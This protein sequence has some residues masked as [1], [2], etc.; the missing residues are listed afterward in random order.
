MAS[1]QIA[2][3]NMALTHLGQRTITS[4]DEASEPARKMKLIWES[5]RDEVLADAE[6]TFATK[7]E[8]LAAV[9]GVTSIEWDYIY[10]KPAR[11]LK[12]RR[13]FNESTVDTDTVTPYEIILLT[14][15]NSEGIATDME[16]AYLKY[17][18][19]V[20]DPTLFS[21]AYAK[22]LSLKLAAD[23][24]KALTGDINMRDKMLSYYMA[25]LDGAKLV[26]SQQKKEATSD[27]SS[28]LDARG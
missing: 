24:A 17:T 9:S 19:Q 3:C 28:L 12:V 15:T 16:G 4:I 5:T 23:T 14:S 2:I 10:Q 22:S 7:S 25:S 13:L 21:P 1:S 27:S 20:T 8:A 18:Y 6:W 11:C 26:N